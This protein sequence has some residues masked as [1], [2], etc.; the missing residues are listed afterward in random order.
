MFYK[1][2]IYLSCKGSDGKIIAE[3][4]QNALVEADNIRTARNLAVENFISVEKA[5][6]LEL[7]QAGRECWPIIRGASETATDDGQQELPIPHA[8]VP[9]FK[10]DGMT[11]ENDPDVSPGTGEA[12]VCFTPSTG[13][14]PHWLPANPVAQNTGD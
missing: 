1:I 13:S 7:V 12:A 6:E 3:A 14:A 11:H 2:R 4:E 9:V 5:T 10:F 8:P